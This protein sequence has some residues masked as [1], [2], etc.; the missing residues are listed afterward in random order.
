MYRTRSKTHSNA[1]GDWRQKQ[2]TMSCAR[3]GLAHV[4]A[5]VP[6]GSSVIDAK[7]RFDKREG[8]AE[9]AVRTQNDFRPGYIIWLVPDYGQIRYRKLPA[10]RELG[11]GQ[12]DE[13]QQVQCQRHHKG[14]WK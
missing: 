14:L 5:D 6:A 7:I 9:I 10:D 3:D 11:M 12:T 4:V 8:M 1:A 2:E 13:E